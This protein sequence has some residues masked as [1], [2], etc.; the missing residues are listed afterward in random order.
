MEKNQM[1]WSRFLFLSPTW[2]K[3]SICI[4]GIYKNAALKE[5]KSNVKDDDGSLGHKS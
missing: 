4:N 5:M 3:S 2:Q 1:I